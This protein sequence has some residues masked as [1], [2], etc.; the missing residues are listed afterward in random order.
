MKKLIVEIEDDTK[1]ELVENVEVKHL[2]DLGNEVKEVVE[3]F[4]KLNEGTVIPPVSIQVTEKV[5]SPPAP[6]GNGKHS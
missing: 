3:D 6:G 1:A 2:C 4:V 5:D